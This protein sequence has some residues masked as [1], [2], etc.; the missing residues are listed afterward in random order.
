MLVS[1][2]ENTQQYAKCIANSKRV[3]WDIDKDVI[4]FRRFEMDKKFLPDGLSMVKDLTF[5]NEKERRFF[6]QV[7]GRTYANMFDLKHQ[8]LFRRLDALAGEQMPPG[9]HFSP[10]A[11]AVASIVLG[12]STW[13][14][15]G[16][17]LLIELFTQA[18]YKESIATDSE[19]SELWKNVFLYLWREESQH[20]ILD[21][22][23]W[24]KEDARLTAEQRDLAVNDLIALVGAMDGI[25]Q[26]QAE[27][28]A[29]Y[30]IAH[31]DRSFTAEEAE[32]IRSTILKAY[33]WQ[34]IVSGVQIHRFTNVLGKLINADQSE[35]VFAALA[36]IIQHTCA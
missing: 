19:L 13:S 15:L 23:E 36:P 18:H 27:A 5:L 28:D 29:V 4:R 22:L 12:K 14:V 10:D 9:Y 1:Q 26:G 7:Q 33:R 3:N 11:D 24:L 30:F 25:L 21:E 2:T 17:T 8:E 34:Y 16:L 20:A 31:A 6:S 35:R 32:Q